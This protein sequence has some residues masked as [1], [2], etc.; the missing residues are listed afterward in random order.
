MTNFRNCEEHSDAAIHTE[1]RQV[2]WIA[3][4][5][6][7]GI[8]NDEVGGLVRKKQDDSDFDGDFH[9]VKYC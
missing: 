2:R 8:R 4:S 9:K 5:R 6:Q 3:T 7:V 1:Y